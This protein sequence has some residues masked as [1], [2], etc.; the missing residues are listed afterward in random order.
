MKKQHGLS[1]KNFTTIRKNEK[2]KEFFEKLNKVQI[3]NG[4]KKSAD[5]LIQ[6]KRAYNRFMYVVS[7]I[8]L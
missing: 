2:Y 7:N 3:L 8:Y 6:R 1:L 5:N 4:I